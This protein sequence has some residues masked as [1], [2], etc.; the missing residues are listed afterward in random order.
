ME[1]Q[2]S[3]LTEILFEEGLERAKSL[4]KYLEEHGKVIGPLHGL[5]ISL[6]V[7]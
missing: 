5:P 3:C 4:D 6:K 2:T 1:I 7:S